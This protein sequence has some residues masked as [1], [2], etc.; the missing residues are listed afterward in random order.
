M[1]PNDQMNTKLKT[2]KQMYTKGKWIKTTDDSKVYDVENYLNKGK[3]NSFVRY[4]CIETK[5]LTKVT[6]CMASSE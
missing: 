1:N 3:K 5:M 6:R 2:W 4:L